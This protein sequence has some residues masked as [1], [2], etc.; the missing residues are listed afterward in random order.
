MAEKC[1]TCKYWGSTYERNNGEIKLSD[2]RVKP[3]ARVKMFWNETEWRKD[4]VDGL[5]FKDP[6]D[7]AFAQDGSDYRAEL[8]TRPE[9]GCVMHELTETKNG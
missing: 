4:G 3:C 9:F 2:T 8:L 7:L 6:S 1:E 5:S